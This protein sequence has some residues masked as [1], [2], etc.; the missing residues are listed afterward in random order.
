MKIGVEREEDQG[1]PEGA[2]RCRGGMKGSAGRVGKCGGERGKEELQVGGIWQGCAMEKLG[3]G[4]GM[5]Q[6]A[7]RHGKYR[8]MQEKGGVLD[9]GGGGQ[10][11]RQ[12]GAG[13]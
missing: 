10:E 2:R 9:G 12:V 4:W 1:I 11:E 13:R 3:Q 6:E 7:G 5:L 8:T